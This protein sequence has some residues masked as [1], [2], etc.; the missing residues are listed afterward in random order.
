MQLRYSEWNGLDITIQPI[1]SSESRHPQEDAQASIQ[2]VHH[3]PNPFTQ[4]ITLYFTWLLLVVITL[5]DLD[6]KLHSK[7]YTVSRPIPRNNSMT[8]LS[9]R[10][11]G[12]CAFFS[13]VQQQCWATVV[14]KELVSSDDIVSKRR[15]T[16]EVQDKAQLFDDGHWSSKMRP[17]RQCYHMTTQHYLLPL[18][19]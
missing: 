11:W 14:G 5:R 4:F 3:M 13:M 15:T 19:V 7:C 9:C 2:P 12:T 6:S 8:F 16:K 17:H 18:S 1:K 10:F